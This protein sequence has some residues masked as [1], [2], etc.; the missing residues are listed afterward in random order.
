MAKPFL[1]AMVGAK[2]AHVCLECVDS[3][4]SNNNLSQIHWHQPQHA[5]SLADPH[6]PS[7]CVQNHLHQREFL[8][9]TFVQTL[10]EQ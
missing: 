5:G 8:D 9:A 3:S 10:G 7:G 6:L 4:G 2:V 1:S